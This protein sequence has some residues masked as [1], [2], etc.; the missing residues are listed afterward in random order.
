L[1]E[2]LRSRPPAV[3]TFLQRTAGTGSEN[4]TF[5]KEKTDL[6]QVYAWI[7]STASFPPRMGIE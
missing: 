5:L 4:R 1:E 3:K 2:A 6:S 7:S